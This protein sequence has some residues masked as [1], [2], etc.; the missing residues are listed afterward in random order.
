MQSS[1]LLKSRA[2]NSQP[3]AALNAIACRLEELKLVGPEWDG[4]GSVTPEPVVIDRAAAWL[5][6]NW[7]ADLGTPEICPTADGGVSIS[8]EWNFVEHSIDVR[9]DGAV[10]EWCQYNPATLQTVET[11]LPMNRQG[12]DTILDGINKPAV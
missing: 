4:P 9:S 7:N 11:E 5:A 1:P 3:S 6:E 10:M 8:W 12:W 2:R